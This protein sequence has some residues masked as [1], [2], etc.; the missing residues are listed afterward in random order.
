MLKGRYNPLLWQ[1]QHLESTNSCKQ[2][3]GVCQPEPQ[4]CL[5]QCT[6]GLSVPMQKPNSTILQTSLLQQ[7]SDSRDRLP[8][9]DPQQQP[10]AVSHDDQLWP[11]LKV[12]TYHSG[13]PSQQQPSQHLPHLACA[14]ATGQQPPAPTEHPMCH[15]TLFDL[16]STAHHCDEPRRLQLRHDTIT[17]SAPLEP[18]N[19]PHL[20]AEVASVTDAA[21][22]SSPA[23]PQDPQNSITV[24]RAP[25][26]SSSPQV[27]P[28]T[29]P[30]G[31]SL[32]SRGGNAA[33]PVAADPA[34]PQTS[35]DQLKRVMAAESGITSSSSSSG[36]SRSSNSR[37]I[38]FCLQEALRWLQRYA[39]E[40][41]AVIDND[42]WSYIHVIAEEYGPSV[43]AC[44][45][46]FTLGHHATCRGK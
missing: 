19:N 2:D 34:Q 37:P 24:Q 26:S 1:Q 18:D 36:S 30:P 46:F 28:A 9:D 6:G 21:Q 44:L 5:C 29:L 8:P 12:P 20:L 27:A 23:V 4:A 41:A 7:S 35:L 45:V 33:P 39:P 14:P 32:E 3:G 42:M 43:L 11:P 25:A 31:Q 17:A 10:Q 13:L 38:H 40:A 16:L 22:S 15:L